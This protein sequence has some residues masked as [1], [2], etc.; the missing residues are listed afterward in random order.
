MRNF[1]GK[2]GE[3]NMGEKVMFQILAQIRDLAN[4]DEGA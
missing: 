4:C 1:R 3:M 2:W